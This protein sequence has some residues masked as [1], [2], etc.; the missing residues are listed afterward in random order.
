MS[1]L[2]LGLELWLVCRV[3]SV[4]AV[5]VQCVCSECAV[6]AVCVQCVC[7]LCSVCAVCVQYV[8]C[9]QCVQCVDGVIQEGLVASLHLAFAPIGEE[10]RT[11][12]RPPIRH[13]PLGKA[14]YHPAPSE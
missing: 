12:E 13:T 10:A 5:C 4:C 3:C 8:Q 11:I 2:G 7:S 9:V 14:S 1:G 6:C